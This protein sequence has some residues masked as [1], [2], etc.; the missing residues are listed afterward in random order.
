MKYYYIVFQEAEDA[1][2]SFQWEVTDSI[3]NW[4]RTH[5]A[6]Y[7]HTCIE[8]TEDDY[9]SFFNSLVEITDKETLLKDNK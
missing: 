3:F 5:P 2:N 4:T 9:N 7:I 8:I 6:A 1:E